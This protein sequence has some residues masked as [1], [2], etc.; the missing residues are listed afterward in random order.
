MRT[1]PYDVPPFRSLLQQFFTAH[2]RRPKR[3]LDRA[4]TEPRP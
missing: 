2:Y 4:F 1:A 3:L